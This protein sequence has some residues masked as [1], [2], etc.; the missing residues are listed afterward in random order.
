MNKQLYNKLKITYLY[1]FIVALI[2]TYLRFMFIFDPGILIFQY[3]LH[4][5]SHT[6]ILGWIYNAL[7]IAIV[8]TYLPESINS[9]KYNIIFWITQISI[10]GMMFSFAVHGYAAVSIS[11]STLHI[12]MS[13]IFIYCFVKD[14][15]NGTKEKL[16]SLKFIYAGL[17]FLFLSSFGPWGLAVIIAN[18]L[19]ETDLYKQAIYFYLHFQYNGWFIFSLTG[20]WLSKIEMGLNEA[21]LK[22]LKSSFIILFI[23]NFPAYFLSLLGFKINTAIWI[24]AFLSALLQLY[25]ARNLFKVLFATEKKLFA[26][27]DTWQIRLFR[28][29]FLLLFVKFILQLI[30]ALPETG[31]PAFI[32]REVS[33]A[34][35]HMIMLG[36]VTT[37]LMGWMGHSGLMDLSGSQ[38]TFGIKL[39]LAGFIISEALLF[40]PA[41]VLWFHAQVIPFYS[42][43]LFVCSVLMLIGILILCISFRK[44]FQVQ[45]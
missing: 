34:Y 45:G 38:F 16:V 20:I 9:K 10:I 43:F 41:M 23:S 29:S 35:I 21:Q 36:V 2:G 28:L 25:G 17:F 27:A 14:V 5:H 13:Y 4:S 11:F 39:F 3:L 44:I 24:I 8:Y 30:S 40:Y 32:S 6:A 15:S 26:N 1:L 7:F 37:G 18:G 42:I 31:S 12:I 19:S 33:I 22:I